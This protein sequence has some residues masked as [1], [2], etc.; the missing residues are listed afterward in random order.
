MSEEL[1]DEC[2][3]YPVILIATHAV[4]AIPSFLAKSMD[5]NKLCI[6]V[7][8]TFRGVLMGSFVEGD[9]YRTEFGFESSADADRAA[10][11]LEARGF[12]IEIL[13]PN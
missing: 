11:D 9:D 6:H 7:H 8:H 3:P 5:P 13:R 1:D 2:E 4:D 10:A 12:R